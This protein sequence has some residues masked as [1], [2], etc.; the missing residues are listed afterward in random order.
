MKPI[1]P[2][3]NDWAWIAALVIIGAGI[4]GFFSGCDARPLAEATSAAGGSAASGAV[5]GFA[6]GGPWGAVIGGGLGLVAGLGKWLHARVGYKQQLGQAVTAKDTI[7]DDVTRGISDF[8]DGELNPADFAN[9]SGAEVAAIM[10]QKLRDALTSAY[11][12]FT[13]Q[14]VRDTLATKDT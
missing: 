4:A 11:S 7:L 5:S 6:V 10:R 8:L 2:N 1:A 13:R 3:R 14:A 12:D 9:K